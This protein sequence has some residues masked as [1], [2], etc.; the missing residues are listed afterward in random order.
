MFC[1]LPG[2][3]Y[4]SIRG[5]DEVIERCLRINRTYETF[6]KHL[7]QFIHFSYLVAKGVPLEKS[8]NAFCFSKTYLNDHLKNVYNI[9]T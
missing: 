1:I 3:I 9:E 4:V 8:E 7:F 2:N 6:P 5:Y